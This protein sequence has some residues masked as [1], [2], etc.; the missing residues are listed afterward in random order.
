[1]TLREHLADRQRSAFRR[2]LEATEGLS[3]TEATL[4]ARP[5]WRR[6]RWGVGLD[7]SIAGIVRHVAT[8]KHLCAGAIETGRFAGEAA[9]APPATDW[10]ALREWL[11]GGHCR[12]ERLFGALPEADLE[13]PLLFEG[14]RQSVRSI[15]IHLIEHDIYHAGQVNLLRQQQQGGAG[16]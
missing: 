2:L 9:A 4:G 3:E 11:I 10:T 7:G 15:L 8:W 14:E 1:M 6:Y 13:R 12:L 5:D 16:R